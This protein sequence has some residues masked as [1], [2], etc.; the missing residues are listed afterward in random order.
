MLRLF[1]AITDRLKWV[2]A[3]AIVE[4]ANVGEYKLHHRTGGGR[5]G[6][7]YLWTTKNSSIDPTTAVMEKFSQQQKDS[8]KDGNFPALSDLQIFASCDSKNRGQKR[9][10]E[11]A[12][13][14]R[15]IRLLCARETWRRRPSIKSFKPSSC[16]PL[17][18][19]QPSP[20]P[21]SWSSPRHRHW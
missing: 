13:K 21:P 4:T 14:E 19:T 5:Q 10:T 6:E 1:Y 7:E 12:P 3:P 16:T 9:D 2:Q 15:A 20:T 18:N 8:W 17:R 11:R